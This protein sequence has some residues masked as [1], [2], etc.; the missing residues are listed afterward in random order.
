MNLK[1]KIE[2]I[3]TPLKEWDITINYGI[4]TGYNEAFIITTE[5]R[6]CK[7][8]REREVTS[9]LI[10]KMLRGRYKKI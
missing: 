6:N 9:K 7:D 1:R 3:G 8:E 4:K 10:R 5:K 2:S